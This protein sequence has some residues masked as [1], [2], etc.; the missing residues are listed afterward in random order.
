MIATLATLAAAVLIFVGA[1][2]TLAAAIGILRLPEFYSRM[3]AASKAGTV[4]SSLMLIAVAVHS[5]DPG[6]VTRALA[7]VVFFLLTAPISAHLLARAAY[8][9]GYR[10]GRHAVLDEMPQESGNER[11]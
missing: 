8:A 7:G 5:G 11:S 9:V 2:F 10:L 3:H 1:L 6:T 4:G